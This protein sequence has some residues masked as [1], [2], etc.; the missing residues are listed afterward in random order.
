MR[1]TSPLR[2]AVAAILGAGAALIAA[3]GCHDAPPPIDAARLARVRFTDVTA[4]AGIARNAPTYDAAIADFDAD[5]RLD[6]YVGNHG[7]GA[8]LLHNQGDGTFRDVIGTSGIAPGGDQHGTGWADFDRDGALDLYVAVGAGRALATKANPFYRGD[9]KGRF[10]DVS[11]V[12]GATDPS[13]RS[14]ALAWLDVDLDGDLDL[15]LANYASPNR[16]YL[17]RGDGTFEDASERYGLARWTATRLAWADYD[18]DG[19]PDL[20]LGGTAQNLRLLRNEDGK[21]FRDVTREAGLEALGGSVQGMA[22]GDYDNDGDLDLALSRGA[23]FADGVVDDARGTLRFAFFAHDEP[24]GFDFVVDP[25]EPGVSAELYEN[26]SPVAPERIRCG[27]TPVAS[28]RFTCD[29]RSAATAPAA[30]DAIGFRLWRDAEERPPCTGCAP[31]QSWRLRWQGKGDH[32]LSGLVR[33]ASQPTPIGLQTDIPRGASIWRNDTGVFTKR[34]DTKDGLPPETAVNGQAVQWADVDADGW[35][36]LYLV[37]SGSEGAAARNVL[38]LNDA[39]RRF[40]VVPVESGATPDSGAGRAVAAHFFDYDGDAKL[41]LFLA[42]GWGAPPF[43]R[44]PYRLLRN[45]SDGG[46]AIV[47]ALHRA[48]SPRDGLGAWIT[49]DACGR[50]FTRYDNGGTSWYSQ[51]IAPVHV[52]LG[53]CTRVDMVEIHWPSGAG[54]RLHDLAVD[55]RIDVTE[56][57]D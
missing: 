44:G 48:A 46:H 23:D 17:N 40:V 56:A 13:G 2:A 32:H 47:L 30:S 25:S 42:N 57:N 21:S 22:F 10:T 7:T 26:G 27:D 19:L 33:R 15:V 4:A 14:R 16:L 9:G 24:D 50:R 52:G 8:A 53:D 36:D 54:Q 34:M 20:L 28:P 18:G 1:R 41:D 31:Q 11:S 37:D 38:L 39:A 6:L 45:T 5:G 55:R 35:L 51:S 12:V 43:D 49:V 3:S 29:A